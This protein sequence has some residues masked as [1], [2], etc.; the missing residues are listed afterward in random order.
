MRRVALIAVL[1]AVTAAALP[2]TATAAPDSA[3]TD[4]WI[5]FPDAPDSSPS[6]RLL[7]SAPTAAAG[8][9]SIPGTLFSEGFSVSSGAPTTVDLPASI[10]HGTSDAV[11]TG[12]AA[13]VTADGEI[14]VHPANIDSGL[15]DGYLA[16]PTDALGTGY[17][18]LDY[19]GNNNCPGQAQ[20]EVIGTQDETTVTITPTALI[21][22]HNPEVAYTK[23]LNQ[24]SAYLAKTLGTATLSGTTIT[25][26]H[27]IAVLGGTSCAQVPIGTSFANPLVEQMPPVSLWGSDFSVEPFAGRTSGDQVTIVGSQS[28]TAVSVT[29]ATGP[30]PGA[31]TSINAGQAATFE[32]E[33]SARIKAAA[34]ILV[35]HFAKGYEADATEPAQAKGDP[36]MVLVPPSERYRHAQTFSTP[37]A[38]FASRYV[39]VTIPSADLGTLK[40][41]GAPVSGSS[42]SAVGGD[43]A[44]SGA[45]LAVS[46]GAHT[47][48]SEGPFGVE[49]Y[50]FDPGALDAFGWPGAWGDGS[51]APV[52]P[53]GPV[54]PTGSGAP[55]AAKCRV[56][57]LRGK[58]LKA[59]KKALIK[60]DCKLGR[61][62]KKK[63]ATKN[64]GKVVKQ[65]PAPGKLLPAGSKV[66]VTLGP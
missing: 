25:A 2:G 57:K 15:S 48:E 28:E 14:T 51:R 59:A 21:G 61:V 31:P 55:P 54:A 35:G 42:F 38:G 45:Q 1:V 44:M 3:G 11:Q 40:L 30:P 41:D 10:E 39:N 62:K 66:K 33:E 22:S 37:A 9:V 47:L 58:K 17:R 20:F 19:P 49:V 29:T 63:G 23:T 32:I 52:P 43:P 7:I 12:R 8:T 16:L 56:P 24:G 53:G 27:P 36:T 65:K 13:H 60:K 46:A 4:F 34:P 18:V 5:G 26:D 50:G 6:H 64:S